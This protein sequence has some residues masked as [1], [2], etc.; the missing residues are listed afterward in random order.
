MNEKECK[1][2][3]GARS[4]N[5]DHL[6]KA[7][8]KALE[9]YNLKR[10]CVHTK[11]FA[12]SV[13]DNDYDKEFD[14]LTSG[15]LVAA[16]KTFGKLN[17]EEAGKLKTTEKQVKKKIGKHKLCLVPCLQNPDPKVLAGIGDA[18]TSIQAVKALS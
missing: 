12:F 2:F 16:A 7:C 13:S 5:K 17:L 6:I 11:K 9:T 8:S 14:A 3:L 18:F 15:C 4:F 10:V 1:T